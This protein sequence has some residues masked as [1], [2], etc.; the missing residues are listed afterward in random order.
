MNCD[1]H[2]HSIYSDGTYTPEELVK[3]AERLGLSAIALT[4]HNTVMG[5]ERFFACGKNSNVT[6][7]GGIE[8]STDYKGTEL[9]ILGLFVPESQHDNIEAIVKKALKLKDQS[10]ID[11]VNKIRDMGYDISYEEIKN[12][13]PSGK[14]N[15][16]NIASVM[17]KKNIVESVSQAF[18]E[19][20]NPKL[21][22]YHPPKKLS[23]LEIIDVINNMG[24][25]S[26]LAHP[27]LN[28][29]T[30]ET[31][32]EF[33]EDAKAHHLDGMEVHYSKFTKE[34]TECAERLAEEFSLIKSGG[35]DFHGSNKPE[36]S[37]GTGKG[38]LS[39]PYEFYENL[40]KR[41]REKNGL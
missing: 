11:V 25:V 8:F 5:L 27:F 1:L 7:V 20:L 31:L 9:H 23:A 22:L 36:I 17:V 4:D 35:S 40:E 28:L 33:L 24:A 41:H 3:E 39:I 13:S 19:F 34:Q 16:A 37:M 2:N 10:N 21:G 32:R 15:R 6:L 14:I 12:A 38:N 29:K 18:E 26:V 30:E